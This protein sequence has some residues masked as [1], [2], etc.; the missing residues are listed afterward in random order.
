MQARALLTLG[1]LPLLAL[2][3]TG[4]HHYRRAHAPYGV[5]IV[6]APP[7]PP[8]TIVVVVGQGATV[9]DYGAQQAAEEQAARQAEIAR[10]EAIR[11]EQE[12]LA[13]EAAERAA[14][15][16]AE[17]EAAERAAAERAAAQQQGQTII[18]IAPPGT[19]VP[20]G[21]WVVSQ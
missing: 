13:R 17:R 20:E 2:G 5:M 10:R 6:S 15:E 7:P 11:R 14:R 18:V 19:P 16:R 21:G 12:R 4:C 9:E 1:L 3:S 8:P